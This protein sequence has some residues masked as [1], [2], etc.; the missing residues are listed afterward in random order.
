M[1]RLL[2][3][4]EVINRKGLLSIKNNKMDLLIWQSLE[5]FLIKIIRIIKTNQN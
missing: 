1:R 4:L 2:N 3:S 5:I